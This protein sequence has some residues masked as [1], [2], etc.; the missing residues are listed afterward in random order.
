[1]GPSRHA[2]KPGADVTA[3]ADPIALDQFNGSLAE[4]GMELVKG[5]NPTN[6]QVG[7]AIIATFFWVGTTNI[8][9]SVT[10]FITTSPRTPVGNKYHLVD[11][12]T[13]GGLSMATYVA[14]NVQGFEGGLFNPDG[15]KI[16]GVRAALHVPVVDGGILIS[17]WTGVAG[18][19]AQALGQHRSA[20][21]SG[22]GPTIAHPGPIDVNAGALA[23]G[24]TLSNGLVALTTPSG[25]TN[26]AT[27]A[28]GVMKSDG[29]Y[30][31]EFTVQSNGGTVDPQWTWDFTVPS[32]W[33]ASVLALNPTPTTGN[34]IVT[35]STSGSDLPTDGYTVTVDEGQSQ[36]IATNGSVT[37]TALTPAD[38]LV[39]LSGLPQ[40][41]AVSGDNPQT[42]TVTAGETVTT[43]FVVLCSAPPPPPANDFM[44]GGGKLGDGREF[45]TFGFEARPT[46]GKLEWV[47]HCPKGIN[48]TSP[49]CMFGKFTFHGTVTAGSYAAIAGSPNCRTWSGSGS[50]KETGS[51]SFTI[52]MACD[53]DTP[54]RGADYIDITIDGYHRA[55]YLTGGKIQLH[56]S[57]SKP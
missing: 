2:P 25:W 56:K 47:Q 31:A 28:D 57:K 24:V 6:P 55:G 17:A 13:A 29:E 34:L 46:G 33:S 44:T 1:M 50:A 23:Y 4:S 18:D 21:G 5:F 8:I 19:F 14:T 15:D 42:V 3:P 39:A 53:N 40:N 48:P 38:H 7:D 26:I 49:N 30:D 20:M 32:F 45:A 41:C 16:L 36:A 54:G 12:V 22:V 35:T 11:F 37:F 52:N 9:D 10:D 27:Q 51:H 43:T